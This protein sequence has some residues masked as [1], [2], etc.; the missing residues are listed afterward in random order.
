M[1]FVRRD[2]KNRNDG[3]QNRKFEPKDF[4]NQFGLSFLVIG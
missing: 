1:L 2:G 4:I 3:G